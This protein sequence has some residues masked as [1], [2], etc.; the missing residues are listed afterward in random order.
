MAVRS[1]LSI[2]AVVRLA[3]RL[4]PIVI[5]AEYKYKEI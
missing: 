3:I 1:V 2:H 4:V 5:Y